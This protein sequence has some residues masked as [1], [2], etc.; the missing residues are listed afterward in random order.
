MPIDINDLCEG[1]LELESDPGELKLGSNIVHVL[2]HLVLTIALLFLGLFTLLLEDLGACGVQVEEIY[3][4]Q[5]PVD[6]PVLGFIFLFRW[7]EERRSRRKTNADCEQFIRDEK[8]V[9]T[10]FFAHQV[11]FGILSLCSSLL[12]AQSI[13]G[14]LTGCSQQLCDSRT[15]FCTVEL[16]SSN[17]RSYFIKIKI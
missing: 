13:L 17:T 7:T 1:W 10:M 16:P 5:K 15:S 3:D 12:K 11:N 8:T 14:A 4:L 9:N 6:G 2:F